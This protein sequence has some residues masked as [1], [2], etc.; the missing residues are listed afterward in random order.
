MPDSLG[1]DTGGF[2]RDI[3]GL[4][5]L[6]VL[7][8]LA[9]HADLGPFSGGYIGVDVFFVLSGFLITSLLVRELGVTGGLSLRRFWARRAR[10]LLPASCL[11][12]VATL[13]AGSFVLAPLAQLDLA[14]DGLAAATFVVN[15]V[16][17][18]QQGD[19]LTADLAPSP[20]LHFWSLAVEEQ[21]YLV[22]PILL[23]LV[24]GY[25]RRYRAAVAGLVAVL[26]PVSLAA[27]VWLTTRNQ[28]WA[29]YGLPTR[30]WEL[31]TGAGLALLAA[32]LLR[33]P[34][35][36]R[37]LLGWAGLAA[38][39]VSAMAF[40]DTTT[41]PG[42]AAALPVLATA[43]VV[44][45]GPALRT[46]PAALLRWGPLQWIGQ[47]SYSIYLWHWPA[48]VLV[49]AELGPLS[50]WQRLA[51]VLASVGVAAVTYSFLENP[52]RH[53]RWLA[54]KARRGLVL[55]GSL[56]GIGAV[57]ALVA[58]AATPSLV[59]S[60]TAA[61][62]AVVLNAS[63]VPL[64]PD[65]SGAPSDGVPSGGVPNDQASAA[66]TS[67]AVAP[68]QTGS[69]PAAA[70][71]DDR[72]DDRATDDGGAHDRARPRAAGRG[73]RRPAGP[74]RADQGGAGQPPAVA[75]RCSLGPPRHLPRRVP[76]RR[77][78]HQARVVRVRRSGVAH[79]GRA[80]R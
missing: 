7:L 37:A 75:A 32:K 6:A 80:V 39:V 36:V 13:V 23:L 74:E 53:S 5:A 31:L 8:V 42:V 1:A 58:A 15:I 30:A 29:F 9:Y 55:G 35:P 57:T 65:G 25:R 4:R 33:I 69:T 56:V 16:F 46:G 61:A 17:A 79:H 18:H 51:V 71:R 2:R 11:V 34:G 49:A 28:P 22:W 12:I 10:R 44:A 24:A 66:P 60:G 67:T 38:V 62:P 54:A 78:R 59:G 64:A 47:R 70:G 77:R 52:V 26:W 14:R 21:F 41:F 50:A 40:S 63:G 27:C 20:L 72:T 73:Q 19:Y 3:E 76:P 48:L 43:A 45:A 68:A